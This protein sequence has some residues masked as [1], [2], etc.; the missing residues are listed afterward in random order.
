MLG[1]NCLFDAMWD[2][3]KSVKQE[4]VLS[5]A[6][7]ASFFGSYVMADK[8]KDALAAFRVMEQYG[9]VADVV[10][11]NSLFSAIYRDGKTADARDF[12][13]TVRSRI[14]PD[15]NTYAILL[16]GWEKEQ[17]AVNARETFD[18][19]VFQTGWD[20]NN[21]STYNSF[22]NALLNGSVG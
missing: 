1:K 8:V 17:H 5:L 18:E 11:L 10:A 7:F 21:F 9:C 13:N 3:I 20:P 19:M 4:G 12:L 2:A 6:T 14:R 22:L 16:E 15:A